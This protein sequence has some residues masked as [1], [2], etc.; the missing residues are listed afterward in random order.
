MT[1][2]LASNWMLSS[3]MEFCSLEMAAMDD[4]FVAACVC[5]AQL[6]SS[7]RRIINN[8]PSRARRTRPA[9]RFS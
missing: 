4:D 7:A 6:S 9:L 1:R 2:A 3:M 8:K 5:R